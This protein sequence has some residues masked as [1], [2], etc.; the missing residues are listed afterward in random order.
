MKK[1][2][3]AHDLSGIG[4]ASL[5]AVLPIIS[6]MGGVVCSL[7]TA[8]L[9]TVTG[10]FDGYTITDLTAQMEKTIDH[11]SLLGV[12]F[13]Y[14]YS[15]FLGSPKQVDTIISA[16]RLFQGCYVVVDPVFADNGKLYPTMDAEM[17]NNMRRLVTKADLITPNLT[18]AQFLL[19]EECTDISADIA[20]DL[21]LRL[22]DMGPERVVIT[23]CQ[24]GGE[25]FVFAYDKK[26]DSFW[27]LRCN[28]APADFHGTGDIF[29]SV[30]VGALSRGD[31]FP[32]A[33][34]LSA[35]FVRHAID[36]TIEEEWDR[37]MGLLIEKVL[38]FLSLPP[39]INCE[40][41]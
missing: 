40:R 4:R 38:G 32:D 28:Y 16:I 36:A 23:G 35:S 31:G 15:G 3:A 1:I 7:P 39:S 33:I 6:A 24:I 30:L 8:V 14:I 9:S 41:L 29:T 37:R 2:I 26:A 5:S 11:W 21:L 25:M 18:E 34:A 17:V 13:D 12:K 10:I 19:N 20:K 22:S 27:R